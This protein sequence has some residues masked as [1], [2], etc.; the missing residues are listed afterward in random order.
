MKRTANRFGVLIVSILLWI[1]FFLP[2]LAIR[3]I[4]VVKVV[5][6]IVESQIQHLIKSIEDETLKKI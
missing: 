1:I 6:S 4:R 3:I 2:R 5:L